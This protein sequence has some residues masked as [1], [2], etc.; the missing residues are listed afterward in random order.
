MSDER[1]AYIAVML[2]ELASSDH[3]TLYREDVTLVFGASRVEARLEAERH[4]RYQEVAAPDVVRGGEVTPRF[5]QTVDLVPLLDHD[6][7]TTADIYARHFRDLG[8]YRRWEPML[9]GE[10]L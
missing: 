7:T 6:L 4:A 9:D 1:Q 3:P 8:L 5:M 10:G 2:F